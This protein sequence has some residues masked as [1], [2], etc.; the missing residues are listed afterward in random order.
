[1]TSI[2]NQPVEHTDCPLCGGDDTNVMIRGSASMQI[3]RCRRDGLVY[4]NP[5]PA[6]RLLAQSFERF[7]PDENLNGFGID[8]R[9]VLEHE[10]E[11]I[12]RLKPAGTL[13]DIGCATGVFFEFFA[14]ADWK[15]FGVDPCVHAAEYAQRRYG[16]EVF[17]GHLGEA[18]WEADRFDVI[19]II[20]SLYYFP[21]PLTALAKANQLLKPDGILALEIPGFTYKLLRERGPLCLLFDGKWSRLRPESYHLYHFSPSTL[22]QLLDKAGFEIVKA[23]PEQAPL[24]RSDLANLFNHLHFGVA[25]FLYWTSGGHF[26][27]AAKELYIARKIRDVSR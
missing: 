16:A 27:I 24:R 2:V 19:T 21:D 7:V 22:S 6:A 26:S 5:R 9:P 10:A 11:A 15:L 20:D 4:V 8:R 23:Q 25:Q 17:C 12:K 1:M 13:L 14:P 18:P 3:V